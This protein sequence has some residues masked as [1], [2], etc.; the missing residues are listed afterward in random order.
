[1]QDRRASRFRALEICPQCERLIHV[2]MGAEYVSASDFWNV[3]WCESC[4]HVFRTNIDL[5]LCAKETAE[6]AVFGE[7]LSTEAKRA[8]RP[9]M[10]SRLSRIA[11]VLFLPFRCKSAV[12]NA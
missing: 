4:D 9:G 1:M 11:R 12:C 5:R 2:A 10:Q 3:W 6:M 8:G 7:E